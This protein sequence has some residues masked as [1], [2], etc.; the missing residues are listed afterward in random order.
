MTTTTNIPTG[1]PSHTS[2]PDASAPASDGSRHNAPTPLLPPA[3]K[4][5]ARFWLSMLVLLVL[6][7]AAIWGYPHYG[8]YIK[9]L[10]TSTKRPNHPA[11]PRFAGRR[12]HR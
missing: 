11:Q 1:K 2:A 6:I 8:P 9:N 5:A 12:G 4:S 7:V 10:F 3:P